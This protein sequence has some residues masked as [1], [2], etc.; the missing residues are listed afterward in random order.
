MPIK[1]SE[2]RSINHPKR[3][4][5]P[6]F[7][8]ASK[9][10]LSALETLSDFPSNAWTLASSSSIRS[11]IDFIATLPI[12]RKENIRQ[13]EPKTVRPWTPITLAFTVFPALL[14]FFRITP[15]PKPQCYVEAP[16]ITFRN[17]LLSRPLKISRCTCF[18]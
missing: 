1:K 13:L 15:I 17:N 10:S 8:A 12:S 3:R 4:T 11:C 18:H 2:H 9:R 16:F 14:L 6:R 7:L 5:L